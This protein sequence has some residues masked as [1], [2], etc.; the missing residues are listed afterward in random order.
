MFKSMTF[1]NQRKSNFT[2]LRGRQKAPF[3]PLERDIVKYAGGYRLKKTDRGLLEISQPIG[4]IVREDKNYPD[5]KDEYALSLRDELTSWLITDDWV[6]LQFD[7]EPGRTYRAIVQ[8]TI[9]DFEKFEEVRH[10][11]VQFIA[12]EVLGSTHNLSITSSYQTFDIKG[13]INT[14][15]TSYTR[16][17]IDT[18]QYILENNVGGKIVLNFNFIE[19]DVLEID[20]RKRKIT[21]NGNNLAV[22]LSLD[23][24]WFELKP[25]AILLQSSNETTMTYTERYS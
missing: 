24:H 21:L 6:D 1:N 10:G 15:W 18:D 2:L 5:F 12:H 19:G 13:Q 11:T 9:E 17:K 14:P 20:Y 25:G 16:F 22:A 4:Y 23:S 3:F 7:D 8:N